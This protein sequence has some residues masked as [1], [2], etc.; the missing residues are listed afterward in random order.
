M[1]QLVMSRSP[2]SNGVQQRAIVA[3]E[4]VKAKTI[5]HYQ[6]G[7]KETFYKITCSMPNLVTTARSTLLLPRFHD[8]LGGMTAG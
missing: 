1:Q 8:W 5:W 2:K 3:V 6:P 4:A 7:A